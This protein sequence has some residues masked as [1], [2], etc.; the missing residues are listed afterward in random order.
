MLVELRRD[1]ADLTPVTT[2][3]NP[4]HR[5]LQAPLLV[6]IVRRDVLRGKATQR[7]SPPQFRKRGLSPKSCTQTPA[8]NLGNLTPELRPMLQHKGLL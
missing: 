5:H 7:E 1:S 3:Q 8:A 4:P 6:S 2:S